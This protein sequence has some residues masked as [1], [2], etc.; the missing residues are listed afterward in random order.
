MNR[1]TS[2]SICDR[3]LLLFNFSSIFSSRYTSRRPRNISRSL[4]YLFWL[5]FCFFSHFVVEM[6]FQMFKDISCSTNKQ[7]NTWVPR[8]KCYKSGQI[9]H[10]SSRSS[11]SRCE[12]ICRFSHL[13]TYSSY[14]ALSPS[15]LGMGSIGGICCRMCVCRQEELCYPS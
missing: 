5:L 7:F 9:S 2:H 3:C 6:C 13:L 11:R 4:L 15:S 1:D 14:S 8:R 10:P 12:D